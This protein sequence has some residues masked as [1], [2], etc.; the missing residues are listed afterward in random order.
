ML[1]RGI[2]ESLHFPSTFDHGILRRIY[3]CNGAEF[4]E[5]TS[6]MRHCERHGAK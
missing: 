5:G 4:P 3:V 1:T 6:E 2:G